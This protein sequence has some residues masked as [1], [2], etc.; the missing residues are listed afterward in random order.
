[1]KAAYAF[2]LGI[3]A[4]LSPLLKAEDIVAKADGVP[5]YKSEVSKGE[6]SVVDKRLL[7]ASIFDRLVSVI[8]DEEGVSVS[9]EEVD[10]FYSERL[11][12]AGFGENEVAEVRASSLQ[13]IAAL[14]FA[15]DN[16]GMSDGEIYDL[17]LKDHS[18]TLENWATFRQNYDSRSKI[19]DLR[20][21]VPRD[22][23]HAK[24]IGF[25]TSRKEALLDKLQR[26]LFPDEALAESEELEVVSA[27]L[28][29]RRIEAWNTYARE[30]MASFPVVV[31]DPELQAF[32]QASGF[33][34]SRVGDL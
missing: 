1:M 22:L 31:E 13:L 3:A 11:E 25:E 7:A 14:E 33:R 12:S 17:K 6:A 15:L 24:R 8:A 34:G 18:L 4:A 30:R 20:K 9:D 32:L 21:V 27:G 19:E 16:P 5:V 10:R 2:A 26:S 23:S 28:E 29:E